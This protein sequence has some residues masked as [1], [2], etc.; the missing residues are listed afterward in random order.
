MASKREE[1][2]QVFQAKGMPDVIPSSEF[3]ETALKALEV[4]VMHV[5][6]TREIR[7][8]TNDILNREMLKLA[9]EM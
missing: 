8:S 7:T 9:D 4:D 6:S 2:Q 3:A 1:N 5:V